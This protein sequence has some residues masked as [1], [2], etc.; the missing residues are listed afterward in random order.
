LS[1][2]E[3][4]IAAWRSIAEA[5]AAYRGL[6]A[7]LSDHPMRAPALKLPRP[8]G[9]LAANALCV[10]AP[11]KSA[12]ILTDLNFRVPAGTLVGIIGPSAAGKS[13]LGR[14]LVGAWPPS[15]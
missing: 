6:N 3:M 4:V 13:T 8:R 14:A 5:R 2:I 9:E 12:A 7:L 10:S 1:P 15:A 11:G